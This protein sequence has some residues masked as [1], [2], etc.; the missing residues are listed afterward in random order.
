[1]DLVKLLSKLNAISEEKK[2]DADK[3][4]VPDWADKKAGK[5]DTEEKSKANEDIFNVLKGLKAIQEGSLEEDEVEEGNEFAQKVQQLKTQGAKAGTRFKT[6]DGKEHVLEADFEEQIDECGEMEMSPLTAPGAGIEMQ[7]MAAM[8]HA[9]PDSDEMP[10]VEVEPEEEAARYTLSIQNGD[11]NLNMTTDVPD[12]IIHIMKLAGVQGKAEVKPAEPKQDSEEQ[13]EAEEKE[14][15]EAW[16]NTPA[17]TKEKEPKAYG[18]IRDWALKGTG[19]GKPG[20]GDR[21][22]PGQGDNPMSES[23]MMEEYKLF[24]S[25]K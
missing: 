22:A 11:S 10:A 4:G 24:K 7:P 14:V 13:P 15:D 2:P 19:Q 17:A 16:G 21:R 20:Y 6:S 25:G 9:E 23:Y 12:E 8:V 1:M 18:D 3:D 5:D